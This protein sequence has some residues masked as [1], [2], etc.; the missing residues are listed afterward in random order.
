[1]VTNLIEKIYNLI[2]EALKEASNEQQY[3]NIKIQ[4]AQ[5]LIMPVD[6]NSII[7]QFSAEKNRNTF[8]APKVNN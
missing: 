1:M 2:L 4:I 8:N 7:N 3:N 6:Q 5:K